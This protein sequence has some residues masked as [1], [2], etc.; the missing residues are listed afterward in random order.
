MKTILFPG[1]GAQFKGMGKDLFPQFREMTAIA[2]D[3]LGY[4]VEKLCLDDADRLKLTQFTQPALYVVSAMGYARRLEEGM[5]PPDFVAGHSLGE[6]NALLAAGVFDFATGLRIVQ[7]RGSLM[8]QA[9]G[10]GMAAVTGCSGAEVAEFVRA[11]GLHDIDLANFNSPAQT[12]IA[13]PRAAIEQAVALFNAHQFRCVA[14]NVS[15]AFHSRYMAEA[16][17]A[18]VDFLGTIA[19][20]A[21]RIPVIA[22]ATARPYEAD[23]VVA[24]LGAQLAS[25]VRWTDSVRYL[26]QAGCQEFVEIGGTMLTR[27]VNDIRAAEPA[28]APAPAA[29]ARPPAPAAVRVEVSPPVPPTVEAAVPAAPASGEQ[30]GGLCARELGSA[31]FRQRFGLKYAYVAGGMYRG[32]AAPKLVAR[33]GRA[34][35]LGFYGTGGLAPDDVE[36]GLRVLRA[37]L[38]EGQA[39]GVNLL[40]DYAAPETE[41]ATVELFLKHQVR[42]IEAAAYMQMTPAIVY[43]R[44]RGLSQGADGTIRSTHRVLAKVSR[45][46]VAEAFMSPAPR[47]IVEQLLAEGKI[48]T[49][50]AR[51]AQQVP[52]SEDVCIE[53]DSG[54]HTDGGIPTVLFPAMLQ[55]K[56]RL[57]AKHAYA[58]PICMGLGGGI[59][60]PEAAAA[61]FI[62]GADF[63]LTG[64]INQ[65]TVDAATSDDVKRM[66]QDIN[67][68]DTEY[69]PAGDMFEVGARV[70]VLI[71]RVSTRFPRSCSSSCKPI[72]SSAASARSGKTPGPTSC[73]ADCRRK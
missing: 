56:R 65:C 4:S 23:A 70:Q 31:R 45:P 54:G 43:F 48:N 64:S 22:N 37:E 27:M 44:L 61:A 57:E 11:K 60:T 12:V 67:V 1:Q 14:L 2:S 38:R 47:H 50:Q 58:E 62:M 18:F 19:F 20:Q 63:I 73:A 49:E 5:A 66:L 41:M 69:A 33:L 21:P 72:T 7:R 16:Q 30:A 29:P 28:P 17:A 25:P 52:V 68:Q 9:Q 35:C 53:A 32:V 13:G 51:L 34:G 8:A 24:T 40:A 46:E 36:A 59:G 71:T 3:I 42:H 26:V 55:L 6:Y 15:G 10:G 39:F